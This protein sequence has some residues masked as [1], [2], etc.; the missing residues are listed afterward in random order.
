MLAPTG[1]Q[2]DGLQVQA[3]PWWPAGTDPFAC[4]SHH[5]CRVLGGG[6]WGIVPAGGRLDLEGSSGEQQ[7][8]AA[9]LMGLR[10]RGDRGD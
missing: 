8:V 7:A 3:R 5:V 1:H 2:D 10:L 9:A 6:E 4:P